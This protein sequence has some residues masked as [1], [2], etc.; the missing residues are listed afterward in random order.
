[1]LMDR[2]T[3]TRTGARTSGVGRGSTAWRCTIESTGP[4]QCG[5]CEA[6]EQSG[7]ARRGAIREGAN[8]SGAGGAKG[9]DQGEC[10]SAKHVPGTEPGKRDTGAGSHTES[11][12]GKEE[13]EVHHALPPHQRVTFTR[14]C[15]SRRQL[16]AARKQLF[17][18]TL[19][20]AP[21]VG[22]FRLLGHYASPTPLKSTSVR[23]SMRRDIAVTKRGPLVGSRARAGSLSL[24][25]FW[26]PDGMAGAALMR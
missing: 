9:G 1:M 3:K 6:D 12:K 17:V 10:G 26:L 24:L 4:T 13:G 7:T 11:R 18:D 22:L 16:L 5:A 19:P 25:R 20:R 8:R 23:Y 2:D 15:W 14:P 21:Q